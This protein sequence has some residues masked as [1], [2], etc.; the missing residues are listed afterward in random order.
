MTKILIVDDDKTFRLS[1]S[2]GLSELEEGYTII[3]AENG[4]SAVSVLN[5]TKIDLVI[6]DLKMPEMD[7][8]ELIAYIRKYHPALPAIVISAFGTPE[9]EKG[10]KQM[11]ALEFAEKPIDFDNLI[12]IIS[13]TLNSKSSGFV[14]GISLASFLQ[15]IALEKKTCTLNV[16][17]D[18]Q[19]GLL[20]FTAGV[21]TDAKTETLS[22]EEAALKIIAWETGEIEI[23][24]KNP[25]R[26]QNIHQPL[27][28]LLMEA[29]RRKDENNRFAPIN[30]NPED[31]TGA[32]P[33]LEKNKKL[34]EKMM[35]VS[36]LNEIVESVKKDLGDG[37]VAVDIW[38]SA[39]GQVLTGYHSQPKAVALFNRVTAQIKESLDRS[40]FPT[41]GEYFMIKLVDNKISVIIDLGDFRSGIMID[42]EKVQLGLLLNIVV[43][44]VIE[45]IKKASAK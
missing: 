28:Y 22:G 7:G 25:K 35:N 23:V 27:D 43:P 39:D 12:Q 26:K 3:A 31:G 14:R 16:Q 8:F 17:S 34:K 41:L 36:M 42:S 29:L 30:N 38:S 4:K 40:N 44:G 19:K 45:S 33:A 9:I 15:L 10:V 11:G 21:L 37:L 2:E 6:T 13:D 5:S 24:G 20:Y 32:D 18:E 1:L